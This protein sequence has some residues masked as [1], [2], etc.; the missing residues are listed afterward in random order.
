[1]NSVS[2]GDRAQFRILQRD[3]ARLRAD[4]ARLT[5]ELAT[6]QLSDQSEALGGDFS[7]LSEITRG[8]RLNESFRLSISD[9][10]LAAAGRQTALGRIATELEGFGASLLALAGN[11]GAGGLPLE[12]TDAPE[13]FEQAVSVLNTQFAGR[14]LFSADAT[15]ATPLLPSDDILSELQTLVA[16]QTDAAGVEALVRGWFNDAGGGYETFAWQGGD[17]AAP[18]VLLSEGQSAS[19]GVTALDPAIR[20]TLAGLAMAALAAENGTGLAEDEVSALV[21]A[22]A[23]QIISGETE[24]VKLRANLGT[25]EARIEEAKVAAE[26]A[27]GTL[28]LE[29]GRLLNADP[30]RTATELESVSVQLESLYIL[31][32]RVSRLSLTEFLR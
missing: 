21:S 1:M 26:T 24:M 14:S 15:E 3:G 13:R 17:G 22:A 25:E 27:R 7:S 29:Y 28:E 23:T 30:Y 20:E 31:T 18:E 4:M 19:P 5:S 6:G 32:A 11:G 8:L 12:L 2:F 16:G 9:A 10:A